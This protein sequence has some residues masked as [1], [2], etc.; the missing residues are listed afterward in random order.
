MTAHHSVQ[1]AMSESSTMKA[2]VY[3]KYGSPD[4]LKLEKVPKPG[5]GENEVLVQ[6]RAASLNALDWRA[7]RANPFFIR[8][9]GQGVLKPKKNVL[10]ADIAGIVEAVGST[11]SRFK[12]GDAVFGEIQRGGFA[13]Y[14][15]VQEDLLVAKPD[16]AS[17]EEAAAL[18]VAGLTAL[19]GLRDSGKIQP[20]QKVLINGASGGVGSYAVQIAKLYGAEV[21]GTCSSSKMEMVRSIG[22]DHVIDYTREDF[23]DQSST[24][25]LIFD[26]AL[27]RPLS[28][29]L[30]ALKP[31]GTYVLAGGQGFRLIQ[32]MLSKGWIYKANVEVVMAE[33]KPK[34]L[35]YL[36]ELLSTGQIRPVIDKRYS[37]EELPEAIR[38]LE[39]GNVKGKAIVYTT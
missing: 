4:E 19:Q 37:L 38:S 16:N 12:P 5:V 14:V 39:A 9:M 30:R 8:F 1:Q 27:Y 28:V 21:T 7:L 18:P 15:S 13:E 10:G 34:D 32:V 3:H 23:A 33:S 26:M 17:F 35:A 36:S 29:P 25:D 24:Y 6:V 11:V 20:G 31:G 22:A 2:M